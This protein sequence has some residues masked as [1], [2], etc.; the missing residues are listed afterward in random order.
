MSVSLGKSPTWLRIAQ[1]V[2]GAIA[3][4]LSGMVLANPGVT[5]LFYVTLLAISLILIGFSKIIEGALAKQ[6][7]KSPRIISI[8]IGIISIAGGFFS[9]VNPVAALLTLILIIAVFILIH[10]AGLMAKGI[11]SKYESRGSRIANI[12]IGGIV[13]ALSAIL[14]VY[15]GLTIVF[16]VMLV[17]IGLL[18]N[19]IGS[20]IS[21]ITGH[22]RITTNV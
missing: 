6:L 18:L 21:G 19:G 10:G 2:L 13:I 11:A 7:P 3:I 17:S 4:A 14:Y 8:I 12:I 20:I 5:T 22:R 16:M 9:L 1:I 15:P